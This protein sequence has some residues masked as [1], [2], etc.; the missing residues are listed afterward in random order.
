MQMTFNERGDAA[1]TEGNLESAEQAFAESLRLNPRDSHAIDG[2]GR[3]CRQRRAYALAVELFQKAIELDPHQEV[4][5]INL[6]HSL[7]E[8]GRF[9]ETLASLERLPFNASGNPEYLL[10][11]GNALRALGRYQE[12]LDAYSSGLKLSKAHNVAFLVNK[13]NVLIDQ[14]MFDQ[15]EAAL[16]EASSREPKNKKI[17]FNTALLRLRLGD[18]REGWSLHENRPQMFSNAVFMSKSALSIRERSSDGNGLKKTLLTFEQGLGDTIQF[19]RFA[20]HQRFKNT[21]LTLHVPSPLR[22]L[23][24]CSFPS[25]R[26]TDQKAVL[27]EHF[28]QTS[29]LL[30]VPAN[31]N[32][33]A[34]TDV[35]SSP[36]LRVS[37]V[38]L[39]EIRNSL[40]IEKE[41]LN[42][43]IQWRGSDNP[44]LQNRSIPLSIFEQI[45]PEG[46]VVF[47]LR[48]E[49]TPSE[50]SWLKSQAIIDVSPAMSDLFDTAAIIENLDVVLTCDTSVAHLAGALGK[51]VVLLLPYSSA[52]VWMEVRSDSPWYP[53]MTLVRQ[54]FPGDW[55]SCVSTIRRQLVF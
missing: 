40:R 43:G 10:I 9:D 49:V 13:A 21:E 51:R 33:N 6:A 19:I 30:S 4:S 5:Q 44:R 32:F 14:K 2:L 35:H 28:D 47:S 48:K 22:R 39:G 17:L 20:N 11:R 52:W 18:W 37:P 55:Q 23:V 3:V 12:S 1:L 34:E 31:L 8:L 7:N 25:C 54:R 27:S 45:I 36:Y 29:S 42:I 15:A 50:K 24:E 46:A 38:V 53:S 26:V 41:R 16:N